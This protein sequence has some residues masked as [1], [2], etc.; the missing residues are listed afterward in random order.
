MSQPDA[1]SANSASTSGGGSGNASTLANMISGGSS[2]SS[3]T[4][5]HLEAPGKKD[6]MKL[7]GTPK[8]RRPLKGS[9]D[10]QQ[11]KICCTLTSD[12]VHALVTDKGKEF[13]VSD[14][15]YQLEH[16]DFVTLL[17][18]TLRCLN[19]SNN[20]FKS[21]TPLNHLSKL[22]TLTISNTHIDNIDISSLTALVHL[23]LSK[24]ELLSVPKLD[25]L[26]KLVNVDLSDNQIAAHIHRVA[27]L[28]MLKV[29]DLSNNQIQ[30]RIEEFYNFVL[31]PLRTQT[32]IRYLALQNNPCAR[33]IP[34]FNGMI[35]TSCPKLTFY[36]WTPITREERA[37]ANVQELAGLWAD[38]KRP[39]LTKSKSTT[40]EAAAAVGLD[41]D[42]LAALKSESAARAGVSD[43]SQVAYI[44]VTTP[45]RQY[46]V[47]KAEENKKRVTEAAKQV[48]QEDSEDDSESTEDPLDALL[49][50]HGDPTDGDSPE[51]VVTTKDSD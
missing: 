22:R 39:I 6:V 31:L 48:A 29:L 51:Q 44:T 5:Q 20:P 46:S 7:P 3:S 28:P 18:A 17:P 9:G 8:K 23:D 41:P 45:R 1:G 2:S 19:M 21:I 14:Q 4:K 12:E 33:T 24:N 15:M 49:K 38:K 36:D 10:L 13:D 11:V 50:K 35:I 43:P 32:K 25:G 40:A 30:M 42:S 47:E 27:S 37:T 34:E 16:T 26:K